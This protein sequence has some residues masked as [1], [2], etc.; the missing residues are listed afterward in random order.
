MYRTMK[1]KAQ[2]L[3]T[4]IGAASLTALAQAQIVL[5]NRKSPEKTASTGTSLLAKAK[6]KAPKSFCKSFG[7]PI[8]TYWSAPEIND[9]SVRIMKEGGFNLI[10]G[11]EKD[12]DITRKY[13]L[14]MMLF[15]DLLRPETLDDPQKLIELNKLIDRVKKHPAMYFYFIVDEPS[16]KDFPRLAKLVTYLRTKDPKHSAYINLFPNYANNSQLGTI[17]EPSAAYKS[18]V[19]QFMETVKPDVLSYDHYHFSS[20]DDGTQYFENIEVINQFSLAYK[21]PFINIVQASTWDETKRVPNINEMRWLNYTSLAYGAKGLSYFV[22][23]YAPF[24]EKMGENSGQM[25]TASGRTTTQYRAAKILNREFT[26]IASEIGNLCSAGAY[27][28]SRNYPGT[29][30][31]TP[32]L[33]FKLDD[34]KSSKNILMGYFGQENSHKVLIVNLNYKDTSLAKIVTSS[35]IE[36]FDPLGRVWKSSKSKTI[37]LIPG[38]GVLIRAQK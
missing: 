7:Q 12:L 34:K 8:T 35:K 17:G 22:Y 13:G 21:V 23:Y 38:G 16:A 11:K 37:R 33:P 25:V 15:S 4:L 3:C 30:Y 18:Y 32:G 6:K 36:V 2:L 20:K 1:K 28:T 27:H 31:L 10:W 19:K 5:P 29:R 24:A 14:K 9:S 26:S